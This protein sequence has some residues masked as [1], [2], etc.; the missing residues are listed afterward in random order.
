MAEAELRSHDPGLMGT[1]KNWLADN[2]FENL[3]YAPRDAAIR[4]NNAMWT[5]DMM[6]YTG[7]PSAVGTGIDDWNRGDRV[8]GGIGA[9]LGMAGVPAALRTPVRKGAQTIMRGNRMLWPGIYGNPREIAETAEAK[10]EPEIPEMKQLW[11]GMGREELAD[12]FRPV[13]GNADP[14][15]PDPKPGSKGGAHIKNITNPR[16]TNRLLDI[17]QAG[18]DHAPKLMTGMTGWYNN[19]PMYDRLVE[20]VGPEEA[21]K[22]FN[23][24][25]ILE[26]MSSPNSDVPTEI[27]R[28]SAANRMMNAG[29]LDDYIKFGGFGAENRMLEGGNHPLLEGVP[30]HNSHASQVKAMQRYQDAG[31][32]MSGMTAP[33]V[34]LYIQS[35]NV[36]EV[37]IQVDKPVADAHYARMVGAADARPTESNLGSMK[38]PEYQ[39]HQPWFTNKV[40]GASD[41]T[42]VQAQGQLWGLGGPQTGVGTDLGRPKMELR[43]QLIMNTA[44]QLGIA[45]EKVRDMYLLGDLSLLGGK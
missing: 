45:P 39:A 19:Q 35:G 37:G 8:V 1:A 7:G 13:R 18:E 23:Q 29:A 2:V 21:V 38:M 24:L 14:V 28:G 26:G 41:R 6:P 27:I 9:A 32:V 22:R 20:L 42:A 11:R 10:V 3:G 44:R 34:P 15:V 36:P 16:N 40:A 12:Q 43:T 30:G 31:G 33:K 17:L 25:N 5:A 4:S